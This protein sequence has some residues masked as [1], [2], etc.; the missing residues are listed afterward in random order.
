MHA[1]LG[2]GCDY[3]PLLKGIQFDCRKSKMSGPTYKELIELLDEVESLDLGPSR[4]T[5]EVLTSRFCDSYPLIKIG[6][7]R[8]FLETVQ[9][10]SGPIKNGKLKGS[11]RRSYLKRQWIPRTRNTL[12]QGT[13]DYNRAAAVG[14][15]SWPAWAHC[16][17]KNQ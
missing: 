15:V 14:V 16:M 5:A 3:I 12:A 4:S 8:R 11:S 7:P 9:R 10:I 17:A 6:R 2:M 13:V 1:T